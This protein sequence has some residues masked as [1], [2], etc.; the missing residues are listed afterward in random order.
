MSAPGIPGL[1][2][3][4]PADKA[5]VMK[6]L[7][8]MQMMES[9]QTYNGLVDRCFNECVS[10]FRAKALDNTE[11]ECLKKCVAKSMEFSQRVGRRFGE[12]NSAAAEASQ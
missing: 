10:T 5:T 1:D 2:N 7:N 8:A 11:T 4:S 3:L 9:I 6:E 12:K